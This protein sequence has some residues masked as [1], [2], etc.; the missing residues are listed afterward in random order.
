MPKPPSLSLVIPMFNEEENIEHALACA[1]DAL[2]RH[3]GDDWEI[4]VVDDASEDRSAA[5]VARESAAE[6]RIRLLR[7]PVNRKL[8]GDAQDRLR[9]RPQGPRPL[10][11]RRPAVR[12]RRDRPRHPGDEGDAGRPDR[13]LPPR[14]H[15]RGAPP[16]DLLLSLQ[17]PDR[18]PLRLASPG[19]Q[20][21]L[22][23]D[24]PRG[25]GGDRAEVRG[26]ADRRRAD[27]Q[28]EEPRLRDPAARP[29]LLPAHPRQIDAL[30]A[31]GHPQDPPRAGD[32]LPR[33]A[34]PAPPRPA[35]RHRPEAEPVPS[36]SRLP[37]PGH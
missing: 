25:A 29:R 1:I 28:G 15:R 36:P 7:H 18:P 19:H 8:G 27:R 26:L 10:H 16:H 31:R 9:R 2:A 24:P 23:A 4:V 37:T 22:Q 12:P 33:D 3:C 6:P 20:L 32:A 5:I 11:G 34:P 13:R 17:L 14:P 21:L 35:G 30:L